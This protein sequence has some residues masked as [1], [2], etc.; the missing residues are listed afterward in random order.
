MTGLR[1][2][3]ISRGRNCVRAE[4]VSMTSTIPLAK[5]IGSQS[6]GPPDETDLAQT[7]R[8]EPDDF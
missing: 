1:S 3:W 5:I 4:I 7:L 2:C 8:T 6:C